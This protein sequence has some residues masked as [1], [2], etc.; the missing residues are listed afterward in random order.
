MA[1]DQN[2]E[3]KG[4]LV[5]GSMVFCC[6]TKILCNNLARNPQ[7]DSTCVLCKKAHLFFCCPYSETVWISLIQRLIGLRYTNDWTQL[8]VLLMDTTS[9]STALCLIRYTFQAVLYYLWRERNCRRHGECPQNPTH[10]VKHIG[11][12]VR[13]RIDSLRGCANGRY[14]KAIGIWFSTR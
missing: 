6:H 4:K 5:S 10:I 8:L 7:G 3:P 2:T 9:E 11:K 1:N 13:N 12:L 14:N